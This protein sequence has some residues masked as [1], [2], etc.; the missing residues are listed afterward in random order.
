VLGLD[1]G[2]AERAVT[3][4]ADRTCRVWKIPEE[5]HLICRHAA[6]GSALSIECCRYVSG[7]EWLSGASDGTLQV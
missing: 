5:S 4:G 3:S 7:T 6:P 2:R 1:V